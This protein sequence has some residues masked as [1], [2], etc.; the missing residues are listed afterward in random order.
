MAVRICT[1][2]LEMRSVAADSPS[3]PPVS[4][5]LTSMQQ[6]SSESSS[7]KES[8]GE[9]AEVMWAEVSATYCMICWV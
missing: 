9:E 8:G 5:F 7:D 4:I 2:L 1:S 6:A 3:C